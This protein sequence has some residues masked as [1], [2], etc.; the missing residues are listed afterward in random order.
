VKRDISSRRVDLMAPTDKG[1]IVKM[2]DSEGT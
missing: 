1:A 2:G